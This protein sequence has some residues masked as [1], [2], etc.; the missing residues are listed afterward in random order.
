V[1]TGTFPRASVLFIAATLLAVCAVLPA[2]GALDLAATATTWS[3]T[4]TAA[5]LQAG[6]GSNLIT[7][8]PSSTSQAT[9]T[10][11]GCV[12]TAD[13][14]ELQ[15]SRSD[16]NWPAGVTLSAQRTG[17]GSGDTG[18]AIVGGLT[19]LT[20]GAVPTTLCTG[21]G[22]R[23]AIPMQLRIQGLSVALPPTAYSTTITYTLVDTL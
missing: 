22:D 5:D 15:V 14:W 1:P 16:T 19:Y 21:H 13:N 2:H 6:A 10:V 4:L 7:T 11:T 8:Y 9:L 17:D 18:S 12:D 3:V 20:I 23:S